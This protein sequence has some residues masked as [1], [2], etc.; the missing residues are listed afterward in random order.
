MRLYSHLQDHNTFDDQQRIR[1]LT[2]HLTINNAFVYGD[3]HVCACMCA[4]VCVRV[5]ACVCA[6]VCVRMCVRSVFKCKRSQ[7]I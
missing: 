1:Q 4:R 2:A 3:A 5:R 6:C 7:R